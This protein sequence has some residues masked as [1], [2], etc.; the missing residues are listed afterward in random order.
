MLP[1]RANCA[2]LSSS[3]QGRLA[4]IGAAHPADARGQ[5][6]LYAV[7]GSTPPHHLPGPLRLLGRATCHD[8]SRCGGVDRWP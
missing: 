1:I 2:L 3:A 6:S 5:P 4:A 7:R 8:C